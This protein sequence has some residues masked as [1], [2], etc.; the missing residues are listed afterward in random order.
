MVNLKENIWIQGFDQQYIFSYQL[1]HEGEVIYQGKTSE[2]HEK[3]AKECVHKFN[4]NAFKDYS[5]NFNGIRDIIHVYK[6]TAKKSIQS[7]CNQEYC[8]IYKK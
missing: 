6:I 8:I 4:N 7:A 3:I 5:V 1:F 2:I